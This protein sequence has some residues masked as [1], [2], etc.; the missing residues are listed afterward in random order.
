MLGN[1]V[2][3]NYKETWNVPK[4]TAS[5]KT[6][7]MGYIVEV[8]ISQDRDAY[9][10]DHVIDGRIVYP[11]AG[12]FVMVWE[13]FAKQ[14]HVKMEDLDVIIKDIRIHEALFLKHGGIIPF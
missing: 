8:D 4:Y 12:Y 14:Q 7:D 2:Q 1:C 13:A 9:L 6:T 11:A 3:W 10:K 5:N